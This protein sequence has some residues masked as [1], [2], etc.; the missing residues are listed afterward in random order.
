MDHKITVESP[1]NHAI[2]SEGYGKDPFWQK[3]LLETGLSRLLQDPF[4]QNRDLRGR[5]IR[6][7]LHSDGLHA[8][9][10]VVDHADLPSLAA[11]ILSSRPKHRKV[12]DADLLS[13]APYPEEGGIERL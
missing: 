8:T 13:A 5:E 11:Q 12:D 4:E 1:F 3:Q 2:N 7:R 6:L 10:E 9:V